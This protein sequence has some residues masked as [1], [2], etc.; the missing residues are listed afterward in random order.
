[1]S[2]RAAVK[3]SARA[4]RGRLAALNRKVHSGICAVPFFKHTCH[5][6]V[7]FFHTH[8]HPF[9]HPFAYT[10]N[11]P[12]AVRHPTLQPCCCWGKSGRNSTSYAYTSLPPRQARKS[13]RPFNS[14]INDLQ[15]H[16]ASKTTVHGPTRVYADRGGGRGG[17]TVQRAWCQGKEK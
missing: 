4:R 9:L 14:D 11:R 16:T 7:F 13:H 10:V 1:M 3:P 15:E 17:G 12:I 5:Y 2:R 8:I 6:P